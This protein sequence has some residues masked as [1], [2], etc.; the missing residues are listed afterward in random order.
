MSQGRKTQAFVTS[1]PE[2]IEM[3]KRGLSAPKIALA[4]GVNRNTMRDYL[5]K[6]R[7]DGVVPPTT[8]VKY[9]FESSY[10]RVSANEIQYIVAHRFNGTPSREL[11]AALKRDPSTVD[12]VFRKWRDFDG[13][14]AEIE[15]ML[16][17]GARIMTEKLVRRT[18]VAAREAEIYARI[19][20]YEDVRLRG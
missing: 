20:R 17:G 3:A 5:T 14:E 4:F 2:I 12:N 6:L 11:A 8:K 13:G 15:A 16:N 7:R 18:D 9:K 10:N 19:G 1:T